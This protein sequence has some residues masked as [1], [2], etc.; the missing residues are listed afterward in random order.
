MA[1][2]GEDHHLLGR[3]ETHSLALAVAFGLHRVICGAERLGRHLAW[4]KLLA[5]TVELNHPYH[6]LELVHLAQAPAV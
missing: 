2:S 4:Q 1:V 5:A 3:A 6:A